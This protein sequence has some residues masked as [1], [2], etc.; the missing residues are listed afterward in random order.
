[1]RG[2]ASWSCPRLRGRSLQHPWL[3]HVSRVAHP[4]PRHAPAKLPASSFTM[5]GQCAATLL[6]GTS[7]ARNGKT[8]DHKA[9]HLVQNDRFKRCKPESTNEKRKPALSPAET[10]QSA[11]G[12]NRGLAEEGGGFV[13]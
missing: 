11:P 4:N 7:P 5:I 12:A 3:W 6:K 8:D 13:S 2:M 9:H 10:D 1:M